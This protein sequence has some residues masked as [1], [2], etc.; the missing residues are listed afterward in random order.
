MHPGL[1]WMFR[2]FR[3]PRKRDYKA[4]HIAKS[5]DIKRLF[6]CEAVFQ[7]LFHPTRITDVAKDF[8]IRME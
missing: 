5:L 7:A 2:I 1:W 4:I 6:F 8:V 3:H